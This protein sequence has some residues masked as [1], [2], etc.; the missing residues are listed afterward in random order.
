M[1][2]TYERSDG[3]IVEMISVPGSNERVHQVVRAPPS[4]PMPLGEDCP[5]CGKAYLVE[6][7]NRFHPHSFEWCAAY[8]RGFEA[9]KALVRAAPVMPVVWNGKNEWW[10]VASSP[11]GLFNVRLPE[12]VDPA[13]VV[14][15]EVKGVTGI[16]VTDV[17]EGGALVVHASPL[18]LRLQKNETVSFECFVGPEPQGEAAR[19]AGYREAPRLVPQ[20]RVVDCLLGG[21]T[22]TTGVRKPEP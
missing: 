15:G 12:P 3:A 16:C 20:W 5:G 19:A 9:G 13:R 1:R 21:M 7:A 18:T 11:G 17:G 4:A 10:P 6:T 22:A 8:R 14:A 2:E